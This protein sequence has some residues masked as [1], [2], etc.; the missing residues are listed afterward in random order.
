MK[1]FI[2]EIRI[3][4]SIQMRK[5][6]ESD[7]ELLEWFG[8][9][10]KYKNVYESTFYRQSKKEVFMLVADFNNFPIGQLW[11]DF[12]RNKSNNAAFIWAV[13]VFPIFRGLGV[14]SELVKEAEKII[15]GKNYLYSEITVNIENK[16]VQK[17]YEKLGYKTIK[18]FRNEWDYKDP[19]KGQK[20]IKSIEFL[21]RK[22]IQD[23][24]L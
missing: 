24:E 10:S 22:N 2:K 5:C 12:T 1:N 15:K 16:K 7:L 18:K 4:K 3:L 8:T 13:R 19:E 14:G 23:T 21:M 9:Y 17:L 6:K 11:I 20:K